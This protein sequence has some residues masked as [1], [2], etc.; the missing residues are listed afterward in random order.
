MINRKTTAGIFVNQREG[1]AGRRRVRAQTDGKTFDELGF[2][3]AKSANERE[4]V[5]CFH[6]PGELAT[7]CFG[8]A[9]AIG[10]EGSH[11]AEVE[12]LSC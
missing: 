8:F 5:A 2:A 12:K 9:D 3:A 7:E 4:D 1:R 6:I 11:E 10:N